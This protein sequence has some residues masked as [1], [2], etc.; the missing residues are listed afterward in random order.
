MSHFVYT[1]NWLTVVRQGKGMER[2]ED[3]M[4]CRLRKVT[5]EA[6]HGEFLITA[7]R[8]PM[9]WLC[10]SSPRVSFLTIQGLLKYY[11]HEAA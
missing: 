5:T 3:V 11:T 1:V 9:S 2:C 7:V 4:W 8:R 10:L 6:V